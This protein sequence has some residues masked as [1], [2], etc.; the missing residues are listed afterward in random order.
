V[1][2]RQGS[3]VGLEAPGKSARRPPRP[4]GRTMQKRIRYRYYS[5]VAVIDCKTDATVGV[6]WDEQA[7]LK[8]ERLAIQLNRSTQNSD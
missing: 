7:A 1:P 2:E 8:A 3:I 5:K 4:K 6:F